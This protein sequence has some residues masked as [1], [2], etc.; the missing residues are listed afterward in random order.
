[1]CGSTSLQANFF[2]AQKKFSGSKKIKGASQTMPTICHRPL[3]SS[4]SLERRDFEEPHS[5]VNSSPN[6]GY[7]VKKLAPTDLQ[8][9][10]LSG[11]NENG[12][13]LS[14]SPVQVKRNLG[15]HR[16]GIWDSHYTHAH[17]FGRITYITVLGCIAFATVKLF[18]MNLSKTG[19]HWTSTKAN[20]NIVWTADSSADYTIGPAYIRGGNIAGRLKKIFAVVKIP[21]LHQSDAGNRLDLRTALAKSSSHIN[22]YRRLMPMEEAETLVKQWQTIK[23]EAL[24]PSHEVNCLAQVLDESM[25]AQVGHVVAF[26]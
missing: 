12:S 15:T 17:I 20:D 4:A 2:N 3:S 1:M 25:L 23:A 21:F 14:E 11:K 16:N 19:S 8:S 22:V 6:L 18:G 26:V 13:S 10:L 7:A 9:S 5:Y 24:G